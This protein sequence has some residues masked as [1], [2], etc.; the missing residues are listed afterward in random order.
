LLALRVGRDAA[1]RAPPKLDVIKLEIGSQTRGHVH[2]SRRR[3]LLQERQEPIG[4]EEVA[5]NIG[6]PRRL[7]ALQGLSAPL[8]PDAGIVHERV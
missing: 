4:Q 6:G 1:V 5:E 8:Q 2:D 3:A 7:D